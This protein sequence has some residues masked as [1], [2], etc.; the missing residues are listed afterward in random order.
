MSILMSKPFW[1]LLY[2]MLQFLTY[3][4]ISSLLLIIKWQFSG[5]AFIWLFA[6]QHNNTDFPSLPAMPGVSRFLFVSLGFPVNKS[7]SPS[8][9]KLVKYSGFF[10]LSPVF[11][12]YSFPFLHFSYFFV[13]KSPDWVTRYPLWVLNWVFVYIRLE[14]PTLESFSKWRRKMHTKIHR[15]CIK[16]FLQ[17][18]IYLYLSPL[19]IPGQWRNGSVSQS[20]AFGPNLLGLR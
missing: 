11:F 5:F 9:H 16:K 6:N 18:N 8:Y 4:L 7:K 19:Y 15:T 17:T 10:T 20:F 2:F 14:I 3:M 1:H 12:R 13:L